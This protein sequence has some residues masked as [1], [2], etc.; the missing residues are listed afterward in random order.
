MRRNLSRDNFSLR[1]SAEAMPA[2]I[3]KEGSSGPS[4]WPDPMAK[5]EVMNFPMAVLKGM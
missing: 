4:D 2:P 1:P 3:C 5:A